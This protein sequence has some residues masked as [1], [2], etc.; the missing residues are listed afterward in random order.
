[1]ITIVTVIAVYRFAYSQNII[2]IIPNLKVQ[3]YHFFM[4]KKCK[5][6]KLDYKKLR[7][8]CI[9]SKLKSI[10]NSSKK[11]AITKR[12]NKIACAPTKKQKFK[13]K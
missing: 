1:M 9:K 5:T 2:K 8:N 12:C 11:R 4:G 7:D 13:F 3:P 10:K 6:T